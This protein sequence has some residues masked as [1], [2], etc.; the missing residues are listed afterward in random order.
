MLSVAVQFAFCVLGYNN[1]SMR[2][3]A[4]ADVSRPRA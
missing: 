1:Q 3:S 2:N 4:L